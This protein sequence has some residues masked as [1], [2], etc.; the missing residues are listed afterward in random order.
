MDAAD[1]VWFLRLSWR[2]I[3]DPR[4]HLCNVNIANT[5]DGRR[6]ADDL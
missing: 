3:D 4:R 1:F 5:P 2:Q 6:K